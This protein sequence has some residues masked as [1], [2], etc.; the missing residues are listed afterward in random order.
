MLLNLVSNARKFVAKMEGLIK[1]QAESYEDGGSLFLRFKVFDNGPGIA[2][3]DQG[4]LFK[5][6]SR[7]DTNKDLNPNG[8]GLGLYICRLICNNLGGDIKCESAP[9]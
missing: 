8:D 2:E 1:V 7:I 9:D 6:F 4:K 5:P 3:A